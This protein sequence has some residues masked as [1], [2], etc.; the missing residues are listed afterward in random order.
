MTMFTRGRRL[1]ATACIATIVVAILHTIGN[2]LGDAPPDPTYT[3]LDAAMRG[4]RLPLGMGMS[5]SVYDI[6]R[7]LVF[8]MSIC[9]AAMGALGL[10]VAASRDAT[11][12]LIAQV[13]TVEALAC[14]ALTILCA[15]YQV[16]PP[17]ISFTVVT[18]LFAGALI[19]ARNAA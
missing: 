13:A 14:G 9:V 7:T 6:Y 2:T 15:I 17:L 8:T 10:V 12:T 19:V 5:P 1:F 4:Y 3:A 11:T 16:P 18:L